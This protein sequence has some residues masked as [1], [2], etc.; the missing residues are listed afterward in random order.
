MKHAMHS[1]EKCERWF[2]VVHSV[3]SERDCKCH[4]YTVLIVLEIATVR[5]LA[6]F[7][8]KSLLNF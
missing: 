6:L 1:T 5:N 7:I 4:L 3:D 8:G 2:T